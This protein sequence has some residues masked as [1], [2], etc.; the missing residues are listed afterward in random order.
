LA[1][2]GYAVKGIDVCNKF[3]ET[4]RND[5]KSKNA[6]VDYAKH[7]MRKPLSENTFDVAILL[8]SSFGYFS[9]EE[10][11]CI[12]ENISKSLGQGGLFCLIS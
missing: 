3:L 11:R 10:N 12:L 2:H 7:D 5:A 1:G 8:F 9:D 4:A 6:Q